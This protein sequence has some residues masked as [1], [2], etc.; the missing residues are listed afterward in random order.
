MTEHRLGE[1][2]PD[3]PI[4]AAAEVAGR[5]AE[6]VAYVLRRCEHVGA[7][8]LNNTELEY[9]E[10]ADLPTVAT[11]RFRG[12]LTFHPKVRGYV[13]A[14]GDFWVEPRRATG[15]CADDP[16]EERRRRFIPQRKARR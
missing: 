8:H 14:Q 1:Y 11:L 3:P 10:G 15:Q 16:D 6:F 12:S 2:N 5:R 13:D 4:S 9:L 7:V